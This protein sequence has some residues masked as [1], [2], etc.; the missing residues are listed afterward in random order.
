MIICGI[1]FALSL[2][3][4]IHTSFG[5]LPPGCNRQITVK[6]GDNCWDIASE[7]NIS[8]ADLL[9]FN[10]KLNCN[11]LRL[12]QVLCVSVA[13]RK[14][15]VSF[16]RS[17]EMTSSRETQTHH[18]VSFTR[19][20]GMTNEK[21]TQTPKSQS[22]K[23][24]T[25]KSG[26]T[27]W[28]IASSNGITLAKLLEFNSLSLNCNK[29]PIGQ[30]V[31]VSQNQKTSTDTQ[32][33]KAPLPETPK[34]P[35]AQKPKSPQIQPPNTQS[36]KS[37]T[38]KTG[39]T[40][41][42]IASSNGI[43]LAKLLELNSLSLNC[44]KLPIGQ[45]VC[46]SQTPKSQ[47][48]KSVTVKS[49]DTCW[50]IASSNGIT[51][52]KLLEFNSLGLNCNKLPIGQK[53][54]VSQ[55]QKTNTDTQTPKEPQPQTSK[56]P[57]AQK[58]KAPQIQPPN[59]Q[60]CKSVTVKTGDTCW[61]IASSN[62][63]TLAKL[64]ELNS[65]S[66][67]CDKLP[68]GQKVCVSQNQKTSADTQT[69]KAPQPQTPKSPQALTPESPQSQTP[70]SPQTE[71]PKS[72]SCKSVTVKSGDTCW[73]I[74]TSNG[75]TLEELQELNSPGLNCNSLAIGQKVCVNRSEETTPQSCQSVTVKSGDTCWSIST[76]NGIT[77][78]ELQEL[79]SP[80]LNCNSLAIG[81]KVCVNRSPTGSSAQTP[82]SCKSVIVKSGDTCWSIFTSNGITISQLQEFNYPRL[83]CSNLVVGQKVC[84][85]GGNSS[86]AET[87]SCKTTKVYS[88][89]TCWSIA[90]RYSLTLDQLT[91]LNPK[92]NCS[93]LQP[94]QL[95][96]I[97]NCDLKYQP[98]IS[99]NCKTVFV[100]DSGLTC[101]QIETEFGLKD[102]EIAK[103]NS[104]YA[105][106]DNKTTVLPFGRQLCV[107]LND[108]IPTCSKEY[109]II[110]GDTCWSIWV[111][112]RLSEWQF[113][114]LNPDIN[115]DN[116]LPG[117]SIC[118]SNENITGQEC[119]LTMA[120][121]PGDTCQTLAQKAGITIDALKSL[122]K[123]NLNCGNVQAQQT[124]C[125]SNDQRF[126]VYD[127]NDDGPTKQMLETTVRQI[128]SG[129]TVKNE[130]TITRLKGYLAGT[131]LPE[132]IVPDLTEI[133][134]TTDGSKILDGLKDNKDFKDFNTIN[135]DHRSQLCSSLTA[136]AYKTCICDT[137]IPF[138]QCQAKLF[139]MGK[140]L[141]RKR[142]DLQ[143]MFQNVTTAV[144]KHRRSTRGAVSIP[145]PLK[146]F[147]D[148]LC[149]GC[150][151]GT[152]CIEVRRCAI[153]F[154]IL[155]VCL[156][157]G[158]CVPNPLSLISSSGHITV[159]QFEDSKVGVDIS[160][161]ITFL[162]EILSAF[163]A[164]ACIAKAGIDYFYLKQQLA[165]SGTI[166][167][168]VVR[169][170][171]D[172]RVQVAEP[173]SEGVYDSDA[174]ELLDDMCTEEKYQCNDYCQVKPG[175]VF[176]EYKIQ[177]WLFGWHDIA[178]GSKNDPPPCK[179]K[180]KK[181]DPPEA[182]LD[183]IVLYTTSWAQYRAFNATVDGKPVTRPNSCK[184][185]ARTPKDIDA[186]LITH[187]N[188]AF[189][190]I[191][192]TTFQLKNFEK[193]DDELIAQMNA[194]KGKSSLKTL[195]S[196]G[197]WSFSQGETGL[198]EGTK[199]I[200][201]NMAKTQEG[202]ARFIASAV[203]YVI[204]HN[205]DGIDIDW[206]YPTADDRD[207]FTSLL[208]ELRSAISASGKDILLTIA[209][210]AGRKWYSN[211]DLE[212][213]H[214]FVDFI[215]LMTYDFHGGSFDTGGPNVNAPIIDCS[216]PEIEDIEL[217]LESYLAAGVPS[218]KINLGM[219]TY[220]RT[221][222]LDAAHKKFS[223][224]DT[225]RNG[226]SKGAGKQG[227]CT[228]TP[229]VLAYYEIKDLV[230]NDKVVIDNTLMSAYAR[231]DS[232]QW[233][234][235]DTKETHNMKMCFARRK[236]LGGIMIWDGEMDDKLELVKNMKANIAGGSCDKFVL[237]DCPKS[238]KKRAAIRTKPS[239]PSK[240]AATDKCDSL[241]PIPNKDSAAMRSCKGI[242]SGAMCKVVCKKNYK[243]TKPDVLCRKVGLTRAV[244]ATDADC[245]L[246]S[247]DCG[248]KPYPIIRVTDSGTA[249][250]TLYY[251]RIDPTIKL[252]IWSLY[253][254]KKFSTANPG[255]VNGFKQHEC[256]KNGQLL[257]SQYN[258]VGY[259]R[260]HLSPQDAFSF[261]TAAMKA[262]NYMINVAPQDGSTNSGI[263]ETLESK[264]K[265]FLQD[266]PGF[267]V[268]GLCTKIKYVSKLPVPDCYWKMICTKTSKGTTTV[269]VFYHENTQAADAESRR[270]EVKEV[271]DQSFILTK[272][273][274][275]GRS[276]ADVWVTAAKLAGSVTG[277]P[278]PTDCAASL[279]LGTGGING[280]FTGTR[281]VGDEEDLTQFWNDNIGSDKYG[282][283]WN[284]NYPVSDPADDIDEDE[285]DE[286]DDGDGDDDDDVDDEFKGA[287][288]NILSGKNRRRCGHD[289]KY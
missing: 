235:F 13:V 122:N 28:S 40:C 162:N 35:Q 216:C 23:S 3:F 72:Q 117:K 156:G 203:D 86:D 9:R 233:V 190:V 19:S 15:T 274:G 145:E 4:T 46:V 283:K 38:V 66:L 232:D 79:N 158:F 277:L 118:I 172:G 123:D 107:K 95:I 254:Q 94:G 81:Q 54:C 82:Q 14:K 119:V 27:C 276:L 219:A 177:G 21:P 194:L 126:K 125:I 280:L 50:S 61:S 143:D 161:C 146:T 165:F 90:T 182:S 234:G 163:G 68:I 71:T 17:E 287:G 267:V 167:L 245:E 201:S 137:T 198:G 139:Q 180:P 73:S 184:P 36:C 174:H 193:N 228:L 113:R 128:L 160:L 76:T 41:W 31:C 7:N 149:K 141:N 105:C 37:V 56:S 52:A 250:A 29:L 39:D 260:G 175:H 10:P 259:H 168:L 256:F 247:P 197:G 138:I 99:P 75:I 142:R 266:N 281:G 65:L 206:E 104:N 133:L 25:V 285:N 155:E 102:G 178:K 237:P 112:Y 153:V 83:D 121:Q 188:Y 224:K 88:G 222:T 60:F 210:P 252:P 269:G 78:E 195:I 289:I 226:G 64:L 144:T 257:T 67:N 238:R 109:V 200:F 53:V 242:K 91:K 202:R 42:S 32:T 205:M 103:L 166:S 279:T 221:F 249:G 63:I 150:L 170:I 159:S 48:C 185:Y 45:K 51:L 98:I 59:T 196:I 246:D 115:C 69:P 220:G 223:D 263:W 57:Q 212:N 30:R 85:S 77:L 191:D 74:S 2:L 241:P 11:A 84:V 215:N 248:D 171:V 218:E 192:E 217:G 271:R 275:A 8:V 12:N 120:A 55:N 26:D 44:N 282:R 130:N 186:S 209:A 227:V 49:G 154:V 134:S 208:L 89:D 152:G 96:C 58:P 87:L 1:T 240:P 106:C 97:E 187:L 127:R 110:P 151:S 262:T 18:S 147:L 239:K 108:E 278:S 135:Q 176:V 5:Q 16:E 173:F 273:T 93:I 288:G 33:P 251:A 236:R 265:D 258:N 6:F 204:Q 225:L 284:L 207:N 199:K 229:G 183:R 47:S 100:Q 169:G 272:A 253:A 164:D 111:S 80:G 24:V 286:D 179:P 264:V 157:A 136:G 43:T 131:V 129:G 114:K 270:K 255:R 116:L 261:S 148:Q 92:V 101:K 140:E 231:Y 124:I 268:T 189:L 22:C 62:G 132:D 20:E 244:W 211:I 213:I 70:K 214:Q 230:P 181:I 34:P 243:A